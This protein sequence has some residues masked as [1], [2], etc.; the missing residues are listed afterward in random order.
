M[1]LGMGH[2]DAH[3]GMAL[4]DV[5]AGLDIA[6]RHQPA[7]GHGSAVGIVHHSALKRA[8]ESTAGTRHL[9]AVPDGGILIRIVDS[10]RVL[11]HNVVFHE[12]ADEVRVALGQFLATT[13][14]DDLHID[15]FVG[16]IHILVVLKIGDIALL[17]EFL[18]G[19]D[20]DAS[21][22]NE[23]RDGLALSFLLVAIGFHMLASHESN[24]G[25]EHE[26]GIKTSFHVAY[27]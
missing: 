25:D 9:H 7:W 12:T 14:M 16:Q 23:L 2:D 13:R 8:G 4:L 27:F 5:T 22:C 15:T 20:G 26:D 21:L 19:D 18:L 6:Q 17:L 24:E 1:T 3:L 11:G 10:H